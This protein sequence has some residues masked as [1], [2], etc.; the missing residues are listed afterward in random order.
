M[1]AA[2]D[3]KSMNCVCGP[4]VGE[5][6]GQLDPCKQSSSHAPLGLLRRRH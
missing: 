2:W 1:N 6:P 5:P 3:A 4:S